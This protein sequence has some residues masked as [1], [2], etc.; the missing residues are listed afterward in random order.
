MAPHV[1]LDSR[2]ALWHETQRWLA[3]SDLHY[4]RETRQ[5]AQGGLGPLWGAGHIERTLQDL[6]AHYKPEKLILVGD[7]MDCTG[8]MDAT[9]ALIARLSRECEVVCIAGNH[10]R[11]ALL[12]CSGFVRCHSEEGFF[13]HHGHC[14]REMFELA[15]RGAPC[16][17]PCTHITG[18]HHPAHVFT[19]GAGLKLKLPAFAQTT[20]QRFVADAAQDVP[21]WVL[22]AFSPWA[23]GA[24]LTIAQRVFA[25][26]AH[27]ILTLD[28]P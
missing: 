15:A 14:L 21:C 7:I 5:R 16:G 22:P 1:L 19:D 4:G 6:L 25:I 8:S 2:L 12:R 17:A 28:E 13:F 20:T 11:P 26:H 3:C 10:D 18:H 24:K 23:S 27:R 9:L